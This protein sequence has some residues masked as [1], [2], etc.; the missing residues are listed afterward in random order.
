MTLPRCEVRGRQRGRDVDARGP[1]RHRE[2]P[3]EPAGRRR[4]LRRPSSASRPSASSASVVGSRSATSSQAAAA[5]RGS[6]RRLL[7]EPRQLGPER[8][9]R[10]RLPLV[11]QDH[12]LLL[13]DVGQLRRLPL[14]QQDLGQPSHRLAR[15]PAARPGWRAA[16]RARCSAARAAR[17]AARSRAAAPA[18]VGAL[19]RRLQL[20]EPQRRRVGEAALALVEPRQRLARPLIA[21]R[22]LVQRPPDADRARPYRPAEPPSAPRRG[23]ARR[24]GV[25]AAAGSR[26]PSSNIAVARRTGSAPP[27]ATC[28]RT[29]SSM[30]WAAASSAAWVPALPASSCASRVG[31]LGESPE[32][33]EGQGLVRP[34][35]RDGR[36]LAQEVE[37]RSAARQREPPERLDQPVAAARA[38]QLRA[39]SQRR[40]RARAPR[41]APAR[42][43]CRP[44]RDPGS[45]RAGSR[46][47]ARAARAART[48]PARQPGRPRRASAAAAAGSAPA[49]RASDS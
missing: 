40:R 32:E 46:R 15:V 19:G 6:P 41:P 33:L 28:S 2:A 12:R 43:P 20:G 24:G 22:L 42:A 13:V 49:S 5:R 36:R 29:L 1:L 21:R 34:R 10:R 26:A 48:A 9:R 37:I 17:R 4:S 39:L 27:P 14:G 23:A 18:G 38:L 44:P 3:I 47:R 25:S 31:P 11:G 35:Q 16:P 45:R 8:G 7:G 30:A